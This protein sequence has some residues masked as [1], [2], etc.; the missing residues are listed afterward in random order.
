ME[1]TH[2][3]Y[4]NVGKQICRF[5]DDSSST[6]SNNSFEL[7][8]EFEDANDSEEELEHVTHDQIS[9]S[10]VD[11]GDLYLSNVDAISLQSK[12]D[13][14]ESREQI[15]SHSISALPL[16]PDRHSSSGHLFS[17]TYNCTQSRMRALQRKRGEDNQKWEWGIDS[18]ASTST[19]D[20]S[21]KG[22][23]NPSSSA[24]FYE[25]CQEDGIDQVFLNSVPAEEK[26]AAPPLDKF[27][28]PWTVA[29]V[30]SP[31]GSF[32]RTSIE[33]DDRIDYARMF[34]N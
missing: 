13:L 25:P 32:I 24:L 30:C 18:T 11:F 6:R 15:Y 34:K 19:T 33:Q 22:Y 8:D 29:A 3:D 26:K 23:D 12:N 21:I 1:L 4:V 9:E 7:V 17:Q 16:S 31:V 27:H 20:A 14:T 28:I 5:D 2:D 10:L